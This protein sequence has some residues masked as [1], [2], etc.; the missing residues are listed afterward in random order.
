MWYTITSIIVLVVFNVL[1]GQ[2]SMVVGILLTKV[3]TKRSGIYLENR[4]IAKNVNSYF[5]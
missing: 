5:I 2:I 4:R 3:A 1:G